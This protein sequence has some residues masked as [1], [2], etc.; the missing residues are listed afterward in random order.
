MNNIRQKHKLIITQINLSKSPKATHEFIQNAITNSTDIALIQEPPINSKGIPTIPQRIR[1]FYLQTPN[2]TNAVKSTIVLFNNNLNAILL[3]EH[4]DENNVIIDINDLKLAS[5]YIEPQKPI[6]HALQKITNFLF[7]KTPK[8]VVIGGDF[9]AKSVFW[10]SPSTNSRGEELL[11]TFQTLNLYVA[12][13]GDTPT[14]DCIRNNKRLTSHIDVTF[15]SLNLI[16]SI[17]DWRIDEDMCTLSDHK[18][19]R[20]CV[21]RTPAQQTSASTLRWKTEN[22]DMYK[23]SHNYII[24]L[25]QNS[26]TAQSFEYTTNATSL[27]TLV[28]TM[29]QSMQDAS[30][31]TLKRRKHTNQ[32]KNVWWTDELQ[33]MKNDKISKRREWCQCTNADDKDRLLQE[34]LLQKELYKKAIDNAITAS[35]KVF[36]AD[37]TK[38]NVHKTL[39][40]SQT[41]EHC[42]ASNPE[43]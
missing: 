33:Q 37:Q 17:T 23:W 11:S 3:S 41:P 6:P 43:H 15:C 31:A 25:R 32:R 14:F 27:E 35:W 30:N 39:S 13:T 24:K 36:T 22:A 28:E 5:I 26:I 40:H 2:T 29:T 18:T 42:S 16:D 20:F 12:N 4:S 21:G 38:E 10:G 8:D 1:H 9:N 34:F 7:N 19:I